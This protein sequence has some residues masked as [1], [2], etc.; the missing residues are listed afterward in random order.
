MPRTAPCKL[1]KP[2]ESGSL[3]YPIRC[4]WLCMTDACTACSQRNPI[5]KG[6]CC[7]PNKTLGAI[8]CGN[9]WPRYMA[10]V[11]TPVFSAPNWLKSEL[12]FSI[13]AF[14]DCVP[15]TCWKTKLFPSFFPSICMSTDCWWWC[16]PLQSTAESFPCTSLL[17]NMAW[18]MLAWSFWALSIADLQG[19]WRL[20]MIL[21]EPKLS[22][23]I[24]KPI[25]GKRLTEDS[26]DLGHNSSRGFATTVE[27]LWFLR[28]QFS[29]N[30]CFASQKKVDH[31][32]K[33]KLALTYRCAM[34]WS[35]FQPPQLAQMLN[36]PCV[37]DVC[38]SS[39]E[40]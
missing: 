25:I 27:Q 28:S 34:Q 39:N 7:I 5:Q 3:P 38:V 29:V 1:L 37:I 6:C 19:K 20:V 36:V 15:Q 8:K 23:K 30:L 18:T 32:T 33:H 10:Y 21:G 14:Q 17:A 35:G 13:C 9:R 2:L 12:I 4:K 11:I 40:S 16:V 22:T 24:T 26:S 31:A